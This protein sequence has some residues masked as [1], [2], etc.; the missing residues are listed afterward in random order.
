[1]GLTIG[2]LLLLIALIVI[3]ESQPFSPLKHQWESEV[4]AQDVSAAASAGG[5]MTQAA[6]A[7]LPGPVQRYLKTCGFVGRRLMWSGSL[8]MRDV[9]FR[10]QASGPHFDMLYDQTNYLADCARLVYMDTSMFGIPFEGLDSYYQGRGGMHGMLGKAITLFNQTGSEMDASELVTW[11]GES[12][13]LV[14]SSALSSDI[15]W[16]PID[17]NTVK[18][19]LDYNGLEVSGEFLFDDAGYL[20]CFETDDRYETVGNGYQR[21]H[22]MMEFS[23]YHEVDGI[24]QPGHCK[25]TW[26]YADGRAPFTYFEGDVQAVTYA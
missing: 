14:P 6:I 25:V 4:A 7:A 17:A 21:N 5:T 1:L 12:L 20:T 16:T 26:Q 15:R 24:R 22:W 3:Y 9:D 8:E 18:A 2:I 19:S 11:L 23:G 13:F 10:T